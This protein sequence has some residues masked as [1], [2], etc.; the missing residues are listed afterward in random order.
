MLLEMFA[1]TQGDQQI[2]WVAWRTRSSNSVLKC[3]TSATI[4]GADSREQPRME[5][6]ICSNWAVAFGMIWA[7]LACVRQIG[8]QVRASSRKKL[9]ACLLAGWLAAGRRWTMS[10]L[11]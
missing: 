3:S 10:R 6:A 7:L 8:W 1:V 11:E 4:K 5:W 2:K 9:W